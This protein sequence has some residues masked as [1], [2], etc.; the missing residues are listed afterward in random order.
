M[1]LP[2][3][4]TSEVE[5]VTSKIYIAIFIFF[6]II[7][8]VMK[9]ADKIIGVLTVVIAGLTLLRP[10][11]AQ[12]TEN[13]WALGYRYGYVDVDDA[14]FKS[15]GNSH[16]LNLTYILSD[17]LAFE[18]EGGYFKVKSKAG[19]KV[20]VFSLHGNFQLRT[21]ISGFIPYLVG[22]L[23]TQYYDY[24]TLGSGDRK[25]KKYSFSYK[26]GTGIEYFLDDNWAVN[27]EVAYIYGNTGGNATLDVYSW[28]YGGGIK[29]Y[30]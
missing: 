25:D 9:K 12:E 14:D 6:Y 20:E 27:L 2:W 22:G 11:F 5:Q 23:G 18:F 8:D 24:G 21:N 15:H 30:F 28:R 17:Y 10:L 13:R 26:A 29:Y 1:V 16:N 19:T 3:D 4:S 7:K